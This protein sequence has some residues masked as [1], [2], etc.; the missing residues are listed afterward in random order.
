MTKDEL[1]DAQMIEA[2]KDKEFMERTMKADSDF[3]YVD[4]EI[5]EKI[6]KAIDKATNIKEK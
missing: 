4:S 3:A 2:S 6:S 1:Y 5:L